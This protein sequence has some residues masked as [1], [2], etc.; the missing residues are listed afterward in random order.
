MRP[1]CYIVLFFALLTLSCRVFAAPQTVLAL[2]PGEVRIRATVFSALRGDG[3]Y[4]LAAESHTLEG[5]ETATYRN[6]R[7]VT[8]TLAPDC[9]ISFGDAPGTPLSI[10]PGYSVLIVG[11]ESEGGKNIIARVVRVGAKSSLHVPVATPPPLP[12]RT[13]ST[14]GSL[15]ALGNIAPK[16]TATKPVSTAVEYDGVSRKPVTVPLVFPVLGRTSWEDSFLAAR[17]GRRRHH[18]QDL[19]TP[20]MTKLV[21]CFDGT[22]RVSQN[23]LGGN[24]LY[25][26]GANG[27]YAYYAHINNDT[28]GTNDGKGTAKYA[29][30][31]GITTGTKVRA[32]QFIAY[33]GNSGNA[34]TTAPHLHFELHNG[35]AVFNADPSLAKAEHRK[36]SAPAL[37]VLPEIL[38]VAE[39]EAVVASANYAPPP[40]LLPISKTVVLPVA[41]KPTSPV[42]VWQDNT[43]R[44][45]EVINF[46]RREKGLAELTASDA[47]CFAAQAGSD[48]VAVEVRVHRYGTRAVAT[49]PLASRLKVAGATF[50]SARDV[51]TLGTEDADKAAFLWFLRGGSDATTLLSPDKT[52]IGIGFTPGA[53]GKSV[54][55]VLLTGD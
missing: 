21:A 33:S 12:A 46:Y 43:R 10:A 18:G 17:S 29:F 9:A 36:T 14:P 44:L 13:V 16:A 38:P 28:P 52:H 20:K 27:W 19:M 22:V 37:P 40:R 32:G 1:L 6:A 2:E 50:G 54:W 23:G 25:V 7:R 3:R 15:P 51:F 11:F 41:P 34:E 35:G 45:L 24:A 55:S 48:A 47:L 26:F 42:F 5:R 30:A 8:L 4:L 31:P 39:P 49:A 53:P